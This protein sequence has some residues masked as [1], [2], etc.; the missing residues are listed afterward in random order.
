MKDKTYIDAQLGELVH[1]ITVEHVSEHEVV[2]GSEPTGEKREEG[3]TAAEQQT[4]RASGYEGST[5][6]HAWWGR[7]ALDREVASPSVY[8]SRQERREEATMK[9][10]PTM[11]LMLEHQE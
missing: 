10:M 5:S 4:P 6:S 2:Y 3:K 8:C 9:L 11:V 1:S 7:P